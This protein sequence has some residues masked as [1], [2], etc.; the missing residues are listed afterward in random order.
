VSSD[1][2]ARAAGLLAGLSLVGIVALQAWR[3][4]ASPRPAAVGLDLRAVVGG[5]VGVSPA[6]PVVRGASLRPG[7]PAARG[8]VRL[9]NQAGRSLLVR[10][11]V[12]GGERELDEAVEV[13]LSVAGRVVHRGPL[14]GLRDGVST[15]L[16]LPRRGSVAVEVAVRVPA[17]VDP[18]LLGRS[19]SWTLS[20][21]ASGGRS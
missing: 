17:G 18:R 15:T 13:T 20:F 7:G 2:W 6:G 21:A 9:S 12:A 16:P 10:P 14:G 3:V 5:E 19:S 8:T 11:V 1:L 4:P